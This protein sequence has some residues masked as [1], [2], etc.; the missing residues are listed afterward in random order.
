M[1][2]VV[3]AV[4]ILGLGAGVYFW[5][6]WPMSS[7]EKRYEQYIREFKDQHNIDI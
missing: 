4:L 7:G 5:L 6:T 2:Y 3:R 1:G